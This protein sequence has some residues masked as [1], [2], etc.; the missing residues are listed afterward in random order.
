MT[1]LST[2]PAAAAQALDGVLEEFARAHHVPGLIF[3]LVADGALKWSKAIG[4]ADREGRRPVT[5]DTRFRIASMTKNTT[6]L[7]ILMLRDAGKLALDAPAA[8][9]VPELARLK[10]PTADSAPITLRDLL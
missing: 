2:L 1:D 3:G 4:L 6:A 9:Y 10:L 8:T 5:I 7:A